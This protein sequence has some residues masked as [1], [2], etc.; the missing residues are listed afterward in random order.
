MNYIAETAS[1][2]IPIPQ[3]S[4]NQMQ[5]A[6]LLWQL[7]LR[8][9]GDQKQ[10]NSWKREDKEGTIVSSFG[11]SGGLYLDHRPATNSQSTMIPFCSNDN[12]TTWLYIH[13]NF[14]DQHPKNNFTLKKK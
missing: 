13:T 11:N 9:L 14:G 3:R 4:M 8:T 6:P 12:G 10:I 2:D 5:R 7:C 1:L